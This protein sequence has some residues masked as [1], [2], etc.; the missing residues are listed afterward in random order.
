MKHIPFYLLLCIPLF[1]TAQQTINGSILHDGLQRDYILY[2]PASYVPGTP[3]PLVLNFHGYTSNAFEQMFY[4]DFRP[5]ADTAG[6]LIV[7]PNGTVDQ[8]GNT[9]WNVGWGT[10]NVDDI[11][12]T[13]DLIDSLSAQY[14]I[15]QNRIYSTGMSNGGFMSYFL[16]C[17]LS[18]RIAAI[19]SVTGSMNVNQLTTCDPQHPMP[20][21]EI[22]GTSD[23]TVA[24]T[25]NIIFAPIPSVL[26][27]W[28]A[29]NACHTPPDQNSI[30]DINT[31]DGCT[32][33]HYLY[34]NG[35]NGV[36]V[37]HY[38]IINGVH[39]WPGSAFGGVGTNQDMNA[40]KE[41]WRFF[42]K[43]DIHGLIQTTSTSDHV[44][45]HSVLVYPNPVNTTITIKL[46]YDKPTHYMLSTLFGQV[47]MSGNSYS[48]T[49]DLDV[50]GLSPGMYVLHVGEK[51][52]KIIKQ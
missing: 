31:G 30:P 2:V 18:D 36:E 28:V 33:E 48:T 42:S 46:D 7:H 51:N 22:H 14:A 11:G 50:A 26:A 12:F 49:Y 37:E 34:A 19:A 43:Y 38:K 15:D 41:I 24:Y 32:A 45:P 9:H 29:F 21:M 27:Y 39:A 52:F 47:V 5:I 13:S 1:S 35:T 44:K 17:G 20:V 23:P 10:S 16:A 4:G 40:S 3:A 8:L 6:F 25:G